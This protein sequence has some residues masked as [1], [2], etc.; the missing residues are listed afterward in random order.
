MMR[1]FLSF[2]S[3]LVLL[4]VSFT[5]LSAVSLGWLAYTTAHQ[6]LQKESIRAVDLMADAQKE[7]LIQT[8]QQQH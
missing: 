3:Q 5:V 6:I 1:D 2:Q 7:T 4:L 8:F